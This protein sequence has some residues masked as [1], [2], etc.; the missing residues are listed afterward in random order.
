MKLFSIL[1]LV[2][3]SSTLLFSARGKE[4]GDPG[5]AP[6][7]VPVY[8]RFNNKVGTQK[9]DL[10]TGKYTNESG[11]QFT[12]SMLQYFVSNIKVRNTKGKEYI[13]PQDSCYFLVNESSPDTKTIRINLPEGEYDQLNF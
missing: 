11:E 3:F 9:L 13:V 12:V 1:S 10:N 2:V 6:K 7:L 4:A 8:I 5:P